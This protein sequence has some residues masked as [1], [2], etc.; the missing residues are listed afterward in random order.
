MNW[1]KNIFSYFMWLLYTIAAGSGLFCVIAFWGR[2]AGYSLP[3]CLLISC[4]FLLA[5]GA[6]VFLLHFFA[7][8]ALALGENKRLAYLLEGIAVIA[9]LGAGL[10]LC[11]RNF[12]ETFT[13]EGYYE[14][15]KVTKEGGVIQVVHGAV[16]L[17]LQLLHIVCLLF[18]NKIAVCVW[19]QVIL[20][21]PAAV[22]LYFAVRRLAGVIPAITMLA[23]MMLSPFLGAESRTL[24][25]NILFLLIYA[26]ALHFVA[27][28]LKKSH[29]SWVLYV[30]TGLV[31]GLVTYLDITGATLLFVMLCILFVSWE[32]ADKKNNS[33]GAAFGICFGSGV[34]GFF[35]CIVLD[36]LLSG[37]ELSSVLAAWGSLY[38]PKQPAFPTA[39]YDG[40]AYVDIAV[41]LFLMCMGIFS[42]WCKR[43]AEKISIWVLA[44]GALMGAQCFQ[45]TTGEMPGFQ[46]LYLFMA[47][48]AGIGISNAFA[49]KPVM[50]VA[51][52]EEAAAK[53]PLERTEA[54]TKP[55]A[56]TYAQVQPQTYTQAQAPE[57]AP[58][59]QYIENPLPLPKKHVAR[60]MDYKLKVDDSEALDYDYQIDDDDDYDI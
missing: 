29:C 40:G 18:G 14:L 24:S 17:Y 39:S 44:S 32:D 50:P 26:I 59:I 46:M 60:T 21:V 20:Y 13:G 56:Q 10:F 54:Q 53:T 19:L 48:L 35:V 55:Q 3:I 5:A 33:K 30:L 36:T 16:Y 28:C 7:G 49:W 1:K 45:M 12:P 52:E 9:L 4:T 15:A 31:I 43:K 42:F 58:A 27:A 8:A 51:E 57:P 38:Q 34:V 25:P 6:V 23:F 11:I 37:K 41:L 2:G 47:V 22:M